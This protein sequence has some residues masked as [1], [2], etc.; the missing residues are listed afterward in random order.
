VGVSC[1]RVGGGVSCDGWRGVYGFG[2]VVW[3]VEG[4]GVGVR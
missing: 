3:L 1:L 2:G 4:W